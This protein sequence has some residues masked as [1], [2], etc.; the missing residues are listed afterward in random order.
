MWRVLMA[1]M[2]A[3]PMP[4]WWASTENASDRETLQV[5]LVMAGLDRADLPITLASVTPPG[6]SRGIEAWTSYDA[7]GI[8]DRILVYTGSD[9]FRC[10]SRPLRMRQCVI[11]L[12]SVLVHEAWHL[13]HG[14]NEEDAYEVQIAFLLKNGAAAEHVAA[15]RLAQNRV[16]AAEQRAT[17]AAQRRFQA[18][19]VPR[20]D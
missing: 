7:T 14:P 10:A 16:V 18:G 9:M 19:V 8:D 15:V 4:W 17:A 12:A 2:L 6:A 5:A 13:E 11:R 3:L 1:T 20:P